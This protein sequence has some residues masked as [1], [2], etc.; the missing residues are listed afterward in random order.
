MLFVI[1]ITLLGISGDIGT[2]P[3]TVDSYSYCPETGQLIF[4]FVG[5]LLWWWITLL[6]W[7][8][9]LVMMGEKQQCGC[10]WNSVVGC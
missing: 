6:G 9:L 7:G 4:K 10:C 3:K 1:A 8:A 2:T 5:S